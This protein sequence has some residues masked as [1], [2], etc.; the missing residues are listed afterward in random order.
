MRSATTSLPAPVSPSKRTRIG[1]GAI[2][3]TM[4]SR[5]A[6]GPSSLVAARRSTR[7]AAPTQMESPTRTSVG[8]V[9]C[10]RVCAVFTSAAL[11]AEDGVPSPRA[12]TVPLALASSSTIALSPS[13]VRDAWRRDT[14][15]A[16]MT[17]ACSGS[18]PM[19][20]TPRE[21]RPVT[22]TCPR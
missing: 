9:T 22:W 3:S 20:T 6:I 16:S 11:V 1:L 2:C 4:R 18:R 14:D 10:S 12:T 7:T 21:G 17:M 13:R 15:G 8:P 5:A 19:P